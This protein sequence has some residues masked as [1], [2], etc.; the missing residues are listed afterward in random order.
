MFERG[1]GRYTP[2]LG[3]PSVNRELCDRTWEAPMAGVVQGSNQAF[4]H[5]RRDNVNGDLRASNKTIVRLAATLVTRE[6]VQL[7]QLSRVFAA[8]NGWVP[9]MTR[10][11]GCDIVYCDTFVQQIGTDLAETGIASLVCRWYSSLYLE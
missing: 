2:E 10:G 8:R 7:S 9:C 11:I 1:Q 4:P 3:S 6:N 5:P